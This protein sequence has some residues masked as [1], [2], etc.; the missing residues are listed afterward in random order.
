MRTIRIESKS[1]FISSQNCD[2]LGDPRQKQIRMECLFIPGFTPR[3]TEA[4]FEMVNGFFY[5]Y[6]NLISRNPVFCPTGS[7]G[8]GTK[9]LFWINIEHPPAGGIRA[10]IFT[11]AD[12]LRL[13][14]RLVIFP[15]HLGTDKLHRG[16][17]TTQMGSAP[18]PSHRKG[19]I[20]RTAWDAVF[21]QGAI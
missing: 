9:I 11:V 15:F 8:I 13:F 3:N 12:T 21:I 1:N 19:R 17:P 20:F 14:G 4:V 16:K 10:G 6:A 18:F 7:T 5:I 2:Q